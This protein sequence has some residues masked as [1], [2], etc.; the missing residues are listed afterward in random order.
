MN[1]LLCLNNDG[2]SKDNSKICYTESVQEM[3]LNPRICYLHEVHN[4]FCLG[5]ALNGESPAVS[6]DIAGNDVY[7]LLVS[8]SSEQEGHELMRRLGK[9]NYL[10]LSEYNVSIDARE[11]TTYL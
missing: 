6:M 2:N 3:D 9:E 1:V 11:K 8:V 7:G 5:D 10:D 4:I